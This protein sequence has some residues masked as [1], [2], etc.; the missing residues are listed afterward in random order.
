V[1]GWQKFGCAAYAIVAVVLI[2]LLFLLSIF[3]QCG[4][5]AS[6]SCEPMTGFEQFM[7]FPGSAILIVAGGIAMLRFFK[8]ETN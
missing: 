1:N 2:P 6:A 5:W 4:A 7:W 8:R 3:G